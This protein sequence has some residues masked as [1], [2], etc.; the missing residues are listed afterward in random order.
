VLGVVGPSGAGKSTL[1]RCVNLLE[2]PT[3][4]QV[5]VDGV[6]LTALDAS[7][8]RH[9]RRGIGMIFQHFN[10]LDSRTALR[11][12]AHPLELAGVRRS[13]REGRARELLGMVGLGDRADARPGQLSGGQKQRVAIAR[14][15]AAQPRVLLC[16]E[17][18]SA[19]DPET[20]RSILALL[21]SLRDELELTIVIVTH[22]MG[23]VKAVCDSVAL[24]DRG[25]VADS[26]RLGD[27]ASR[28][29]SALGRELLPALPSASSQGRRPGAVVLE[30][31]FVDD[32]DRDVLSGL[33]SRF[34]LAPHVLGGAVES[35]GG[36]R[37]GRLQ[38]EVESG[39][40]TPAVVDW[41]VER[42]V[43]A[44]VAA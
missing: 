15:L 28:P 42:G 17:A 32:A 25:R 38:L 35:I 20:T 26:G 40:R 24:V 7:R 43:H 27:V 41:I 37:F 21:R 34:S 22:E 4:G 12:V 31:T 14:A 13:E 29:G 10:L 33:V 11:N 39:S 2:R 16:D 36:R 19:L 5:R 9:A 1:I 30:L 44:E 6:E 23:V 18:T 8:L 3:S